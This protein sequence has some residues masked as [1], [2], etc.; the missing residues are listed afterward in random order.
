M[1]NKAAQCNFKNRGSSRRERRRNWWFNKIKMMRQPFIKEQKP[2][3]TVD[4]VLTDVDNVQDHQV[5]EAI[6]YNYEECE[7]K[8]ILYQNALYGYY[9]CDRLHPSREGNT[10]IK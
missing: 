3:S 8:I 6:P 10:I 4:P 7:A 5:T 9:Q 1:H 2:T